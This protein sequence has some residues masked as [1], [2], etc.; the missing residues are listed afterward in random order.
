MET[1]KHFCVIFFVKTEKKETI[2]V[3]QNEINLLFDYDFHVENYIISKNTTTK[4]N[5][6]E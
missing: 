2:S 1:R 4:K 5:N 3:E 6:R